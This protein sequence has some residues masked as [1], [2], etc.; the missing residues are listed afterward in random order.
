M[1]QIVSYTETQVF[2]YPRKYFA[3]CAWCYMIMSGPCKGENPGQLL[4]HASHG[5]CT[6]C[7]QKV[8]ASHKKK[9]IAASR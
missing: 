2:L 1:Y 7:Q 8:L 3:Q 9:K 4:P 6:S 5:C